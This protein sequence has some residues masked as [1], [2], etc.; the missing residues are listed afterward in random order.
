MEVSRQQQTSPIRRKRSNFGESKDVG[1]SFVSPYHKANNDDAMEYVTSLPGDKGKRL[2]ESPSGHMIVEQSRGSSRLPWILSLMCQ[3]MVFHPFLERKQF[4]KFMVR[5]LRKMSTNLQGPK[6]L[7]PWL[8]YK[9]FLLQDL[10]LA[11][12]SLTLICNIHH[13]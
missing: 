3:K 6:L 4:W 5:A 8:R 1:Y 2:I 13:F 10:S 11:P 7:L 9:H 12:Y